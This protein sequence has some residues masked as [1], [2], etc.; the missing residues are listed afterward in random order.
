MVVIVT[1]F[2]IGEVA[3]LSSKQF[4]VSVVHYPLGGIYLFYDQDPKQFQVVLQFLLYFD[5]KDR[6]FPSDLL[7]FFEYT[8]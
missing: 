7:A 8:M 6:P 5:D 2:W 3:N 4:R 1:F